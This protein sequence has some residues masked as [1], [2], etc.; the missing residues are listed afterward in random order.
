MR[1]SGERGEGTWGLSAFIFNVL[2]SPRWVGAPNFPP[3]DLVT[4]GSKYSLNKLTFCLSAKMDAVYSREFSRFG[5][6]A[7][8]GLFIF[9]FHYAE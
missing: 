4:F 3:H 9:K 5:E 7:F 8:E 2:D 6:P 1:L